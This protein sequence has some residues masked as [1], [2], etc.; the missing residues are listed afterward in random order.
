DPIALA[1]LMQAVVAK[2][3]KLRRQNVTF[4]SYPRRLI[5]ENRWRAA[6]YGLD[7]KLIDF[8]RR[9]E[10]DESD[11]LHEMLEFIADEVDELGSQAEMAHIEKIIG[12][13]TGADRQLAVYE[14]THDIKAVVDQIIEETY[15]GLK[16]PQHTSVSAP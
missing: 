6:R 15:E 4:R 2:L 8:G 1:A 7:G 16:V 3:H 11:L 10:M 13:G 5:D 9:C 12:E 14:Q